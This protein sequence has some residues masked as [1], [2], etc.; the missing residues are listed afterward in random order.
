MWV[1]KI[2]L[3]LSDEPAG[4]FPTD[5]LLA[6][7]NVFPMEETLPRRKVSGRRAADAAYVADA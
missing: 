4:Y 2:L 7:Q 3:F 6:R 5:R 1:K